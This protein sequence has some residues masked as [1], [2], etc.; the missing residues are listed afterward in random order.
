M[1]NI[2]YFHNTRSFYEGLSIG[3]NELHLTQSA[4]LANYLRK[5]KGTKDVIAYKLFYSFLFPEWTHPHTE[6]YIRSMIR[7][8]FIQ[9][10]SSSYYLYLKKQIDGFY[11]SVVFLVEMGGV[12]LQSFEGYPLKDEQKLLIEMMH[13]LQQDSLVQRY[14][15]ERAS[16]TKEKLTQLLGLSHPID[17]V[18]I[19]HFDY[20]DAPRM[21]FFQLLKSLGIEVHFY[22]PYHSEFS[23]LYETWKTIYQDLSGVCPNQWECVESSSLEK[24]LKFA[25]YL[26]QG[27]PETLADKARIKFQLYDHPTSFKEYLAKQPILKDEHDVITIF[28]KEL[29]LLTDQ[30]K[31]QHFYATSYGKFFLALQNAKKTNEGILCTYDDYVN[32]MI[33]GWIQSG[34]VNGRKAITLLVDL[35]NYMDGVQGLQDIIERL[36]ALVELKEFSGVFDDLPKEQ[37]GRNRLKRYLTN[38]FRVLSYIHSSRYEITVKQLIECTKDLGR[39]LNH[40]L[41]REDETRNVQSYLLELNKIYQLVNDQ[42]DP[43]AKVQFETLFAANIPNDWQFRQEELFHLLSFYLGTDKREKDRIENFDQLVG[44]TLSSKHIHVTGLSYQTF[45][46][47]SPDLPALLNHTWLK[48]CINHSFSS[49]NR[50]IRLHALLVDYKSRKVTRNTALYSIFHLLAFSNS[51]ITL[52]YIE[53]LRENDGPSIYFTILKE[54]YETELTTD[55]AFETEF[56][57]WQFDEPG[58]PERLPLQV[59]ESIPDLIWLDSDFC[60]KKFFLTAFI[61]QHPVYERDFH[62]QIVFSTVGKLLTEQGDGELEV[63][64]YLFPLFPQWTSAHKQNLLDTTRISGLRNYKSYKNIYYPVAMKRLQRL[65]SRYEV[66]ENWKAKNQY[67]NDRFNLEQHVVDFLPQV[68]EKNVIANAGV[69]CRMCPYLHVCKEGEFVIDGNDS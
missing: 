13:L 63:R 8:F 27:G 11:K 21:M 31:A 30:S 45:P 43:K 33:S 15:H 51:D 18:H 66:G 24:G 69:H 49:M 29:N 38:P 14:H 56:Y 46:W 2:H 34:S 67:D 10:V 32:M 35:R 36:Q 17:S 12:N 1:F 7:E 53:N 55:I 62:Q 16:F 41:L 19:H 61:E 54:L 4:S 23:E 44:A 20:L 59:F 25:N 3:R 60:G 57:D 5:T 52:S 9:R 65:Y 26:K 37:T 22:I 58:K 6:V 40:L 68:G 47:K 64:E 39:K 28:D 42:W 50:E 48:H